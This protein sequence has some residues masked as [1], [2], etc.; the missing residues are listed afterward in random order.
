MRT[1]AF[2]AAVVA[3]AGLASPAR[4]ESIYRY[5]DPTT[6]RDVF[7]NRLDQVPA[8]Y[9]AT[10]KLVVTDGVL[11]DPTSQPD[12]D[13][14]R[15]AVI[16]GNKKPAGVM[17][18]LEAAV[19]DAT[20]SRHDAGG[21]DRT[22]TTAI[23][24]ALVGKG[25]RPLSA[26]EVAQLKRMAVQAAVVLA[27]AGLFATVAWI[28]VMVHAYRAEHRWW[29]LFIMLLQ[30]PGIVYVLI[31]VE[32]KRRWFK[33]ATLFAQAAPYAVAVAMS[34]RFVAFFRAVLAGS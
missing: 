33:F 6:K 27:V 25:K 16:Y 3:L 14:P 5:R 10:A 11:A 20:Q 15:G 21:M 24:T 19:R 4:A 34:W 26:G 29:M 13:A 22:L 28:L 7:V 18:T 31:H 8:E 30:L 1:L 17:E 2:W 32:G 23:D 12:K 9:R